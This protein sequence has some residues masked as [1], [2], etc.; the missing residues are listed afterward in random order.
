VS[1]LDFL[2]LRDGPGGFTFTK[3]D[4]GKV[5]KSEDAFAPD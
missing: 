1:F 5:A 3:Q 2:D 4:T